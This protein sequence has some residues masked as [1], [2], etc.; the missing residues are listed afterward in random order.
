MNI[1]LKK[2]FFLENED[3]LHPF[4]L[5][6]MEPV[7]DPEGDDF[8]C[9]VH[10]PLLLKGDKKIYGVDVDQ[11]RFLSIMFIKQLLAGKILND[12]KGKII[13]LEAIA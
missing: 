6:I 9:E 11:A 4:A 5:K 13:D 1:F 3:G 7:K 10:I 2:I 8:F 12:D